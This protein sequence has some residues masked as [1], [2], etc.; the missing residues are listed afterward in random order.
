MTELGFWKL[1]ENDRDRVALVH[2]DGGE[3]TAG[4]LLDRANQ[5]VAGLREFGLEPGDQVAVVQPNQIEMVTLYLAALQVGWR[6]TPINHHLVGPEIAYIVNDSESKVFIGHERF[7]EACVAT[8]KELDIGL[9]RC[10][11]VGD[12]EGFRPFSDLYE[13][14]PTAK[15]E[16]RIAGAA[17]H[18]TSGTTGRPKGVRRALVDIDPDV[19]GELMSGFQGM[20]GVEALGD[21]VH[22]CGSPMYHTAPLMWCG[23]AFH[24]GHK[25]VL[26]DKWDPVRMMELIDE[27]K[28]TWSHMVPTQFHRILSAIPPEERGKYDVSSLRSM[29]HAA[30][31]CPPDIKREMIG[32]WGN[33]I[34]EYYAATEGGGTIITAEEWLKK[35]GSVGTAWPGSEI[36]I[37]DDDHNEMPTGEEG[38]VYMSLALADFEYKGD[39]K[40]TKDNRWN[41]FFTVGDWGLL[42]EDGYLFLKDRKSDMII[43][44]GV[45]IYPAEIEAA[46]YA[47]PGVDD[48]AV[49]GIPHDDWGEE[50][51]AVVQLV[52]GIEPDD[53]ARAAIFEYLEANL[54][55]FKTPKTIDFTEQLPRDPSGKL[56]KRKLRDPYWE[57]R[58]RAI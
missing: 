51:K 53:A 24:L 16:G 25:V 52:P 19:L 36:K 39:E 14:K 22:I 57:G 49:F 35:P 11:A 3:W 50:I 7:A 42:D 5:L 1:A 33:A 55:K 44:G 56:F 4:E 45:N 46:M 6:I 34:W 28:V 30:A 31:P 2:A 23:A 27:H 43:S 38:T 32:W 26:M 37:L 12:V 9:E 18:Y 21:G 8:A 17:M 15:P 40:K 41:G 13:G 58:D 54:A 48:V 20:F 10:F 47:A 29:V